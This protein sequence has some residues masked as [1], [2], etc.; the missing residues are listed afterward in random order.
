M[1]LT[2][3][4]YNENPSEASNEMYV[5]LTENDFTLLSVKLTQRGTDLMYVLAVEVDNNES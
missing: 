4:F 2:R 3:L 5:W 1:K